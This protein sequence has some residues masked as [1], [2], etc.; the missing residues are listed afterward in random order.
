M[1]HGWKTIRK[2][3]PIKKYYP[4]LLAAVLF[5]L[6][7]LTAR[8][9]M[10]F[11]GQAIL[12]VVIVSAYIAV[13]VTIRMARKTLR[14]QLKNLDTEV[15]DNFLKELEKEGIVKKEGTYRR[16]ERGNG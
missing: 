15:R 3:T 8:D 9:V 1:I 14:N 12:F 11:R 7:A 6:I 10:G 5:A 4:F 2:G 13:N 16:R